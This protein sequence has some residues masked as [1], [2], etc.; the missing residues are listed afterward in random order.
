MVQNLPGKVFL[1]YE[2]AGVFWASNFPQKPAWLAHEKQN[3]I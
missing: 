3:Q 1:Q 2:R